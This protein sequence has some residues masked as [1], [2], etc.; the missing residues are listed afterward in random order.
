MKQQYEELEI[1][2]IEFEN[3]DV[4]TES[5]IDWTGGGDNPLDGN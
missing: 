2:I 4:I 1:E 5:P 3:D